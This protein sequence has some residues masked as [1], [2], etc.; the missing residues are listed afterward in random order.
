M[1]L[2]N[3]IVLEGIDGAG[4]S[5]QLE[6]LKSH[7]Y[8]K[9]V[10]FTAEPTKSETGRFIRTILKGDIKLNATTIAYLFAADRCEHLYGSY[11]GTKTEKQKDCGI[12]ER[13]KSGEICISDRYLF[14]SLA[15]QSPDCG[16]EIPRRLNKTFPLPEIVFYFI[17]SPS[18]SLKRITNRDVTEIYEKQEF[19]E[20]TAREY[21]RVFCEYEKEHPEINII[22]IDA[23]QEPDK[24]EKII[25]NEVSK[26][27][28]QEM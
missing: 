14:S 23:T 24:I 18:I 22:R 21:E 13:T 11:I 19:L 6:R 1:I 10:F 3:F 27:P 25:W 9:R 26:L 20:K 15:Y 16:I 5:T 7:L 17:I 8:K 12:V 4:T 28:I 2:K